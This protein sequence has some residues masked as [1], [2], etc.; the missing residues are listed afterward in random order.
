MV[1]K[2][3]CSLDIKD[4]SPPF[5]EAPNEK[6]WW[7]DDPG[8]SPMTQGMFQKS[9]RKDDPWDLPA[10][11]SKRLSNLLLSVAPIRRV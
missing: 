2:W 11:E 8:N 9:G 7:M 5:F 6:K 3:S 4:E 10:L 1:Y